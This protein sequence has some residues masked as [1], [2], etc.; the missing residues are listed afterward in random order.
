MFEVLSEKLNAVFK[1][2]GSKGRLTEKDVDEALREVRLALLE[3]DVHFRVA[4]DFIAKV[5]ERA[6]GSQVLQ[7]LSPGQQVVKIV[8]EELTAILSGGVN[9]VVPGPQA[10][11]VLMLVG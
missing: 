4:K 11:S 2:L 10:P 5:K 7:S 3:A 8:N 6:L 1:P 9:K